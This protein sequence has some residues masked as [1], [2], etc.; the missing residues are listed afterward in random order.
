MVRRGECLV[1]GI[2]WKNKDF[3]TGV[4]LLKVD[5]DMCKVHN[6]RI[7]KG[8]GKK[9]FLRNTEL[10]VTFGLWGGPNKKSGLKECN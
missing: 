6:A 10:V 5:E 1:R 2:G 3:E 9:S 7:K 4:D 8:V